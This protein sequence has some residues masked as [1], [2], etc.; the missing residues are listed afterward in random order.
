MERA[1]V[2][3]SDTTM[4]DLVSSNA[5]DSLAINERAEEHHEDLAVELSKMDP[6]VGLT[7]EVP[8]LIVKSPSS[9]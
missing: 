6:A 4:T 5:K 3:T 1:S 2:T 7:D 8:D 9:G